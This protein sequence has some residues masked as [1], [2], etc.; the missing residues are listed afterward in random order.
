MIL[1]V[2]NETFSDKIRDIFFFPRKQ[3][4][5][6]ESRTRTRAQSAHDGVDDTSVTPDFHFWS[7]GRVEEKTK[8]SS[9]C[10]CSAPNAK[11]RR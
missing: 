3:K 4:R 10:R 5:F 6:V 7:G 1:L 2:G 11:R 9:D 8:D